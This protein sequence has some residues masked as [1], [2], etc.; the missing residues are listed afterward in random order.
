MGDYDFSEVV[1]GIGKG[2]G[3]LV[4]TSLVLA[5]ATVTLFIVWLVK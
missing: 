5:V 1:D 3:C 4:W 2:I